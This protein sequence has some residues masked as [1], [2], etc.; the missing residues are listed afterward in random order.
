MSKFLESIRE[1]DLRSMT[2]AR[3]DS[4]RA[5]QQRKRKNVLKDLEILHIVRTYTR[6]ESDLDIYQFLKR[7]AFHVQE[8][9]KNLP[10]AFPGKSDSD[11]EN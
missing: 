7:I 11:S 6:F 5:P 8:F 3:Q 9:Q 1:E 2:N 4:I 10:V